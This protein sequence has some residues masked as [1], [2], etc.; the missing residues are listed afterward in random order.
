MSGG[1]STL[2]GN[3]LMRIESEMKGL[4][5]LVQVAGASELQPEFVQTTEKVS[6]FSP[7]ESRIASF[8][9]FDPS[10]T[11]S[12]SCCATGWRRTRLLES[13]IEHLNTSIRFS[14]VQ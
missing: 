9:L 11:P 6:F 12:R 3:E 5:M 10:L 7:L 8:A 2:S 1:E 4:G 13:F 14:F